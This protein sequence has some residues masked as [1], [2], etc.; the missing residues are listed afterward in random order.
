MTSGRNLHLAAKVRDEKVV[1]TEMACAQEDDQISMADVDSQRGGL[2]GH[3][4]V[5]ACWRLGAVRAGRMGAGLYLALVAL[6]GCRAGLAHDSDAGSAERRPMTTGGGG[7]GATPIPPTDRASGGPV[8]YVTDD[9]VRRL[10][11]RVTKMKG[12]HLLVCG[13]VD[14]ASNCVCLEPLACGKGGRGECVN[15]QQNLD[16]FRASLA[17]KDKGRRVDCRRAEVGS[18]GTFRY[19]AFNGD[20]AR[21][22]LS[23]FDSSGALVAARS[24]TDYPAFC[25]GKAR[26]RFQ[27]RVPNCG[28]MKRDELICGTDDHPLPRPIEDVLKRSMPFGGGSPPPP[29]PD[30]GARSAPAGK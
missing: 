21:D 22:D 16:I 5:L 20:I 9:E 23:W 17:G 29:R 2:L 6:L 18:C 15:L 3:R 27:G 24:A 25:G 28:P 11:A 14:N 12:G 7:A 10:A 13:D 30:P 26:I 19:F 4:G 1:K 8:S